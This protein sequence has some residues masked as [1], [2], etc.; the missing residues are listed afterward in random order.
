MMGEFAYSSMQD[1]V[2]SSAWLE[3]TIDCQISSWKLPKAF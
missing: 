3:T 2:K 1:G